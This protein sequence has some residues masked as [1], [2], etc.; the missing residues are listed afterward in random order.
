MNNRCA[1][2]VLGIAL[3]AG[4]HAQAPAMAWEAFFN[5]SLPG[6]D[7]AR[8]LIVAPDNTVYVTG[9]STNI[10]P[11][12]T[13]STLRYASDGTQLWADHPYGPSQDSQNGGMDM[14][15]DP[16]GHVFVCGVVNGCY[17]PGRR[18]VGPHLSQKNAVRSGYGSAVQS[19]YDLGEQRRGNGA[20][21]K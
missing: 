18:F 19:R 1:L 5:G 17:R 7:E 4:L 2:L 10:A 9:S 12:G 8:A 20:L 21:Y 11:Q 13:I 15:I 16:W 3:S 6:E 14:A